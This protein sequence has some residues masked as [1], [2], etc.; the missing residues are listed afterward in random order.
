[1]REQ[2]K[3]IP[4]DTPFLMLNAL[5][6]KPDGGKELYTAYLKASQPF[7]EKVGGK[8]LTISVPG[9]PLIGDFDADL[10]F[11]VEY[12]NKQAFIDLF[13][14]PGYKKIAHLRENAITK[15]LLVPCY[16]LGGKS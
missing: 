1:M 14:D 4:D 2:L 11:F 9:V 12:P 8:A 13:T 15:S 5:W 10:I 3:H 7:A 6:Y 16:P